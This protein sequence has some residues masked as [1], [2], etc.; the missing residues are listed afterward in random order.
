M[1]RTVRRRITWVRMESFPISDTWPW[2]TAAV[3]KEL[4]DI[5]LGIVREGMPDEYL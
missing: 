2:Q 4:D 1:C 5:G 3:W